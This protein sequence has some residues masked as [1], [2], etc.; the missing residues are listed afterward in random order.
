MVNATH[1]FKDDLG[2]DS[3]DMVELVVI[4]EDE[5]GIDLPDEILEQD[6][7]AYFYGDIL[8]AVNYAKEQS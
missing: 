3:L 8:H 7:V 2:A 6:K 5:I 1:S 4:I